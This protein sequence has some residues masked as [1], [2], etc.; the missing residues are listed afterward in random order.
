MI[1]NADMGEEMQQDAVDCATQALE[2]Y[3]IEKVIKGAH[4]HPNPCV[5]LSVAD[6]SNSEGKR[7]ASESTSGKSI[8]DCFY[9][10]TPFRSKS[11]SRSWAPSPPR[12]T[13]LRVVRW[14][15]NGCFICDLSFFSIGERQA[16]ITNAISPNDYE[17]DLAV[18]KATSVTA[19]QTQID[20]ISRKHPILFR[21]T[22]LYR[23]WHNSLRYPS[24]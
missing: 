9:A 11:I 21:V 17:V 14:N 16:R 15:S 20:T 23:R 10:C 19:N 8:R 7:K 6:W 4:H 24:E 3:N 13:R 1:K 18:N 2:K 12:V 22:L 5:C